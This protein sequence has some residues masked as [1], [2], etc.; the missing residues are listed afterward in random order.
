[1]ARAPQPP[2]ILIINDEPDLLFLYQLTLE[3]A[4]YIVETLTESPKTMQQVKRFR[5]DVIGLDWMI[6]DASGEEVLLELKGDPETRSIPVLIMTALDGLEPHAQLL[7]AE[8]VLHKPFR[9]Q[10]LIAAFDEVLASKRHSE[11][12]TAGRA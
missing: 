8:R 9:T 4:G 7:G 3:S 11:V 5:P 6:P 12:E 2:R 1:M 10:Q